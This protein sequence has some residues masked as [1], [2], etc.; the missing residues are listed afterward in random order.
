MIN[1]VNVKKL[2]D[3]GKRIRERIAELENKRI[4]EDNDD[5]I[6]DEEENN[7]KITD[8]EDE[9]SIGSSSRDN[10]DDEEPIVQKKKPSKVSSNEEDDDDDDEE[11]SDESEEEESSE[12]DEDDE[13]ESSEGNESNVTKSG[14]ESPEVTKKQAVSKKNR[15]QIVSSSEED[16]FEILDVD[17]KS[18][19]SK[20]R[21]TNVI[22]SSDDEEHELKNAKKS[23]EDSPVIEILSDSGKFNDSVNDQKKHYPKPSPDQW[24]NKLS[25]IKSSEIEINNRLNLLGLNDTNETKD[26]ISGIVDDSIEYLCENQ[27][28]SNIQETPD[29]DLLRKFNKLSSKK[30]ET[31]TTI[32][33]LKAADF[34]SALTIN[35]T[36]ENDILVQKP[37]LKNI[38]N[39][40]STKINDSIEEVKPK[41]EYDDSDII[42]CS[43]KKEFKPF[44]NSPALKR[45][46]QEHRPVPSWSPNFER[47]KAKIENNAQNVKK[48]QLIDAVKNEPVLKKPPSYSFDHFGDNL[49]SS[50][51]RFR[52][53]N[54]VF[55]DQLKHLSDDML[56]VLGM[57]PYTLSFV[58][59]NNL[60]NV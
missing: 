36:P 18:K 21:N 13:D 40:N 4:F 34:K 46:E 47:V 20:T 2:S 25:N 52:N 11:E 14:E 1:S 35:D 12:T 15:I 54:L 59:N 48:T 37:T 50:A 58:F 10:D 49:A 6:T 43:P 38:L 39:M 42:E 3:G 33:S 19:N 53:R 9:V 45:Y 23:E 8:D 44:V 32:E 7:D 16:D 60:I 51:N 56:R 28:Q 57:I 17:A 30:N 24:K 31:P 26:S 29:S 27:R 22:P 55:E 41:P 5:E